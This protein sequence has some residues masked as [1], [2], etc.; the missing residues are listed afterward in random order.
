[1][2]E[3]AKSMKMLLILAI[4]L[5]VTIAA[6][7][8]VIATPEKGIRTKAQRVEFAKDLRRYLRRLDQSVPI[9]TKTEQDAL[10]AKFDELSITRDKQEQQKLRKTKQL[11]VY[12]WRTGVTPFIEYL[13][14]IVEADRL[15]LEYIEWAGLLDIWIGGDMMWSALKFLREQD[16]IDAEASDPS[17]KISHMESGMQFDPKEVIA[18]AIVMEVLVGFLHSFNVKEDA[19]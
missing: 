15:K 12:L 2:R 10:K 13:D 4:L 3:R 17:I 11:H 18:R 14:K 6:E 8:T 5:P 7:Q 19:P 9:L 1:M 16:H